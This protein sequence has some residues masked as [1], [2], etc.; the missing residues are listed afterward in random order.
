MEEIKAFWEG[1]KEI[2]NH[3]A[4]GHWGIFAKK[5]N[6]YRFLFALNNYPIEYSSGEIYAYLNCYKLK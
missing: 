4:I 2:L 3:P 1:F 5:G 6:K